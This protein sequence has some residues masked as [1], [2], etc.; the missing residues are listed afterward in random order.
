MDISVSKTTRI[1]EHQSFQIRL[2]MFDVSNTR[3]FGIP[4]ARISNTGF[5]RQESTNG[6][7]RNLYVGLRYIF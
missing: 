2:D 6:G 1:T 3:N 5:A 4:E 7:S